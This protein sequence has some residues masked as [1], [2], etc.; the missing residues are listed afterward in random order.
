MGEDRPEILLIMDTL[1]SGERRGTEVPIDGDPHR[2]LVS[3]LDVGLPLV[4]NERRRNERMAVHQEEKPLEQA[5]AAF[6]A[7]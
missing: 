1:E 6:C 7:A 2:V 3:K 5:W 4:G